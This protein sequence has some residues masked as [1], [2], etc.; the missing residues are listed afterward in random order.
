MTDEF[1][2]TNLFYKYI[3][4][5]LKFRILMIYNSGI[6]IYKQTLFVKCVTLGLIIGIDLFNT[7]QL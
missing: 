6:C 3:Y 7:I 4:V 2:F 5:N 1:K